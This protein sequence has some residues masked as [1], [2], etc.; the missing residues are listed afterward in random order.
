VKNPITLAKTLLLDPVKSPHIF[1]GGSDAGK[2]AKANGLELVDPEYFWT[3][4]RWK[5]HMEGLEKDKKKSGKDDC[6]QASEIEPSP[7][8]TVGAVAVDMYGRIAT[9]TSTRKDINNNNG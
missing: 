6:D 4:Q 7:M 9:A 3:E 8:E 5:Q 2:Y 1:L